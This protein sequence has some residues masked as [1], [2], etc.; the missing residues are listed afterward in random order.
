MFFISPRFS[1]YA[2]LK[3]NVIIFEVDLTSFFYKI[4]NIF[5]YIC[6]SGN[7]AEFCPHVQN[8]N[9][10]FFKYNRVFYF[11]RLQSST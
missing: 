6:F 8:Y 11:C 3:K 2:D 10:Q 5:D 1:T 7:N 9:R 4:S